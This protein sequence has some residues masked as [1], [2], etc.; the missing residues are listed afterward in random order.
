MLCRPQR[1]RQ[2]RNPRSNHQEIRC[3]V[4][5]IMETYPKMENPKLLI[6]FPKERL[7]HAAV[8]MNEC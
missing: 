1:K 2:T 4:P 5:S 8:L 3:H 6:L 7:H